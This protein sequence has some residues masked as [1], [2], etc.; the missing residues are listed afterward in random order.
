MVMALEDTQVE[1]HSL[2]VGPIGA[3]PQEHIDGL[4]EEANYL[5]L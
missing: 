1:T 2:L 5:G 3:M 4:M